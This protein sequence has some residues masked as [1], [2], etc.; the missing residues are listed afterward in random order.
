[1]FLQ[2][3]T[4]YLPLP[5]SSSITCGG[6]ACYPMDA[7]FL[8]EIFIGKMLKNMLRHISGFE[9]DVYAVKYLKQD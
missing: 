8:V 2:Y 5:F 7:S 3:F 9:V 4:V 6:L 1:M